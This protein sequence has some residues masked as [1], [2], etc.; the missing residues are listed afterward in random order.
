MQPEGLALAQQERGWPKE[1]TTILARLE[2]GEQPFVIAAKQ[3][4]PEPLFR[5]AKLGESGVSLAV[6]PVQVHKVELVLLRVRV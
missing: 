4:K 3:S 2:A 5:L 1:G 6:D